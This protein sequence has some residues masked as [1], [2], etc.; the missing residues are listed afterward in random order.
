MSERDYSAEIVQAVQ[1]SDV[2]ALAGIAIEL[3]ALAEKTIE[4]RK[5]DRVRKA[6]NPRN[7]AEIGGNGGIPRTV[8][9]PLP[10]PTPPTY[11]P[12][13]P[14]TATAR[15][16]EAPGFD[17]VVLELPDDDSRV[18][19]AGYVAAAKIPVSVVSAVRALHDR[20]RFAWDVI[21]RALCE[22][23]AD[24][25][26]TGFNAFGVGTFCKRVT[27]NDSPYRPGGSNRED[28]NAEVLREFAARHADPKPA[29]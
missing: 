19:F 6:S 14:T 5:Q 15:A 21:G 13:S 11:T 29:A 2:S 12:I 1:R 22:Y 24:E 16:R 7:S 18:I 20:D 27:K 28:R 26:R 23:A 4:R 9:S 3:L 17:A 8:L 25:S 10:S